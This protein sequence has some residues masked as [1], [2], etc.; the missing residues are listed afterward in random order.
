MLRNIKLRCTP[1]HERVTNNTLRFVVDKVRNKLSSWDARQLSLASRV[2]LAQ[3]VLLSI[4]SY[5]MQT[6][7]VLKGL[8]DEIK[9]I[10]RKFVWGSTNGN[11][12]VALISWDSVCQP[13]SHGGLSLRHLEDHNTSFMMK[14]GFNIVSNVNVLWVRVIRSKYEI[15]SGLPKNLSRGRCSFLWRS[16]A[17]FFLWLALKRCLLTNVERTRRGIGNSSACGFC[18]HEY[19][20]VLRVLRNCSVAR[21]IW[22]K[23]ILEER[24]SR[25]FL[26]LRKGPVSY[27][28]AK[29]YSLG[30]KATFHK[31]H[32]YFHNSYKDSNW[33]SLK[34]DG[35]VTL[36]EGFAATGGFVCDHND[37][38]IMG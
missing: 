4:P 6:V 35:S 22:D 1:F 27:S 16:I 17:E 28:W 36:D 30:L 15:P 32:G 33:V 5:F 7:M 2:T 10:V 29:Q 14:M 21:I 13:K 19:E 25:L 18:G 8:C 11:A 12:K 34:M 26:E 3:L 23:L 9:R 37:G 38:W 31:A 24:R 20:D